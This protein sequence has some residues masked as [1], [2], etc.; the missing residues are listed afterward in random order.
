VHRHASALLSTVLT[1]FV[2]CN[3]LAPAAAD[4]FGP[5]ISKTPFD[6]VRFELGNAILARGLSVHS[7]GNFARMLART[8]VDVGSTKPVYK[9]AEF[10]EICSA[11]YARMMV[12]IDPGLISNCPFQL[13]VFESVDRPGETVVGFRR[14]TPGT[15]PATQTAIAAVEA[16]LDG[17]VADA[18]K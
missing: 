5:R 15:S 12:E 4:D 18:V 7:E 10:V 14:L 2:V 11:R 1:A 13:Y 3:T 6:D 17:I 9:H 16:M 8:G